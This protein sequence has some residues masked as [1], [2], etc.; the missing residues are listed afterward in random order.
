MP[1]QT[2]APLQIG[3]HRSLTTQPLDLQLHC[4]KS[5]PDNQLVH[6]QSLQPHRLLQLQVPDACNACPATGKQTL[7]PKLPQQPCASKA[8]QPA[9]P[10]RLNRRQLLTGLRGASRPVYETADDQPAPRHLQRHFAALHS[11][12][13]TET[14]TTF[15]PL[16]LPQL[17]LDT[18][19][20]DA[21]GLCVRLCPSKALTTDEQQGLTF[22]T[23]QCLSCNQCVGHCPEQALGL[24]QV[25]HDPQHSLLTLLREG[26]AIRCFD[27]GR[28]FARPVAD[29]STLN[30]S[31]NAP[32]V[33]PACR[34]DKALMQGGFAS[35]FG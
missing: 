12:H 10:A 19:R 15:L 20:C 30:T 1:E 16:M 3:C 35:L 27:C 4:L 21:Q 24:I 2:T 34:K 9:A 11:S 7:N 33:C 22:N 13:T 31:D 26:Q 17:Q 29:T 6:W 8:F 23:R 18:S 28:H 5:L 14:K 25:E 32:P